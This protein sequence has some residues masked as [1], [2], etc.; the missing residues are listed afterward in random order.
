MSDAAINER[1]KVEVQRISYSV[2][3]PE[4]GFAVPQGDLD[5]LSEAMAICSHYW[6]GIGA[7]MIPVSATG[8]TPPYIEQMLEVREVEE[9]FLHEALSERAR[10]ALEARFQCCRIYDGMLDGEIHPLFLSLNDRPKSLREIRRPLVKSKRLAR[11][12]LACWGQIEDEDLEDWRE[13]TTR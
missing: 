7:L 4:W 2:R 1:P 5:A 13:S 8:R 6:N 3:G 10:E 9:V 12:A 11:I